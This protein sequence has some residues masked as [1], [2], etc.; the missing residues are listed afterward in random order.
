MIIKNN[1]IPDEN[2]HKFINNLN[3]LLLSVVENFNCESDEEDVLLKSV[4]SLGDKITRNFLW[5]ICGDIKFTFD[6]PDDYIHNY[7]DIIEEKNKDVQDKNVS[8]VILY[9]IINTK[10]FKDVKVLL[11][12]NYGTLWTFP[13]GRK[14]KDESFID[15][16][17]RELKEETSIRYKDYTKM[18]SESFLE[19]CE[20]VQIIKNGSKLRFFIKEFDNSLLNISYPDELLR[21]EITGIGWF[22]IDEI[23][24]AKS[25]AYLDKYPFKKNSFKSRSRSKS[26]FKNRSKSVNDIKY[27]KKEIISKETGIRY[28]IN[29]QELNQLSELNNLSK[30]TFSLLKQFYEFK[31]PKITNSKEINRKVYLKLQFSF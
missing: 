21:N 16:A 20:S 2:K 28:D 14:D 7:F 6:R 29:P 27:N 4:S 25:N 9:Q 11:V 19:K 12:Q 1:M 8:G 18:T 24:F 23:K 17:F 10:K 30:S 31:V 26:N 22:G 5:L 13:K 15:C 3:K